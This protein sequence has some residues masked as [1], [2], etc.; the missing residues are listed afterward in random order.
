MTHRRLGTLADNF[1]YFLA[2]G[3]QRNAHG[4]QGFSG[5]AFAF[6]DEAEQD[7]LGADVIVVETACLFLCQHNDAA[8]TVGKT[9]EHVH[10]LSCTNSCNVPNSIAVHNFEP[11]Y[12]TRR[13]SKPPI[14]SLFTLVIGG[15]CWCTPVA[16][17]Y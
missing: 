13:T 4:F 10:F 7:V 14:F 16:N 15:F 9:L 3:F 17:S 5:H 6:V 8:S 1:F 11:A 12:E 2:H